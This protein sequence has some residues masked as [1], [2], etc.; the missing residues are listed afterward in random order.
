MAAYRLL[1]ASSAERTLRR[2]PEAVASAMVEFMTGPLLDN[3]ARVGKP[4]M[5]DLEGY[6]SA[7]RGPYR[8]TCRVDE[9]ERAVRVVRI[10]HRSDV[11][12]VR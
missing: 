12:R 10:E 5:F 4:L 2:L 3:P 6:L 8:V 1:V 11:Y 7:R 9:A